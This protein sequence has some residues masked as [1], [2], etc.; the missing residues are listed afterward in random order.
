MTG[1]EI[2]VRYWGVIASRLNREIESFHFQSPPDV[3]A[4]LERIIEEVGPEGKEVLRHPGLLLAANGRSVGPGHRL[5]GGDTVD[6]LS[7]VAGG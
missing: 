6:F 4:L 2:R 1:V 7:A 3:Q 5:A